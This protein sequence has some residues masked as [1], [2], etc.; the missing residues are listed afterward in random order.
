MVMSLLGNFTKNSRYKYSANI[1]FDIVTSEEPV[2][3]S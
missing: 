2:I 1:Q 3:T